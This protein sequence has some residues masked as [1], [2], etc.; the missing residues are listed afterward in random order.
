MSI[1]FVYFFEIYVS[2]QNLY[3]CFHLD[4]G[5]FSRLDGFL[6]DILKLAFGF[7]FS[8]PL[9]AF[10]IQLDGFL[11]RFLF[12]NLVME[13]E[14]PLSL[15]FFNLCTSG[16]RTEVELFEKINLKYFENSYDYF[17]WKV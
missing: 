12:F 3:I 16:F 2:G 8:L 14:M 9:F 6:F 4:K 13:M 11:N 1:I 17:V 5:S 15:L 7:V 10:L